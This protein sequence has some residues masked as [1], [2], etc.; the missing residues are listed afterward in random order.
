MA[1]AAA[2]IAVDAAAR[3]L[4][5]GPWVW[6]GAEMIVFGGVNGGFS[7]NSSFNDTWS[8]TSGKIMILYQR[9]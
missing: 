4:V 9:P 8:Y 5:R 6:T 7:G 3:P 2:T 1:A